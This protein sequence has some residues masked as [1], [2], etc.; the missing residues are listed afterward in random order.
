MEESYLNLINMQIAIIEKSLYTLNDYLS[1]QS[2]ANQR[3]IK[4][5]S[6]VTI[7]KNSIN[8]YISSIS[9]SVYDLTKQMSKNFLS[10][11]NIIDKKIIYN[12]N[13]FSNQKYKT[14]ITSQSLPDKTITYPKIIA[15]S[16]DKINDV[17][18]VKNNFVAPLPIIKYIPPAVAKQD[19]LLSSDRWSLLSQDEETKL[20]IYASLVK[21][22]KHW[23]R[24]IYINNLKH[25]FNLWSSSQQQE[26]HH[27]NNINSPT[28]SSSYS[29]QVPPQI[30]STN[31]INSDV[32][33]EHQYSNN[34]TST[35]INDTELSY[36]DSM[37]DLI[38]NEYNDDGYNGDGY[39]D[40]E[41]SAKSFSPE[42]FDASSGAPLFSNTVVED[43]A[44]LSMDDYW[45]TGG[46]GIV[47]NEEETNY[48]NAISNI[49]G[50]ETISEFNILNKSG[51]LNNN[52]NNNNNS[53]NN[54]NNFEDNIYEMYGFQSKGSNHKIAEYVDKQLDMS[55]LIIVNENIS[56]PKQSLS[57]LINTTTNNNNYNNSINDS[58]NKPMHANDLINRLLGPALSSSSITSKEIE[59]KQEKMEIIASLSSLNSLFD[60]G[61]QV[62]VP[63]IDDS[64]N[65]I[66]SSFNNNGINNSNNN[67]DRNFRTRRIPST[68]NINRSK[69]NIYKSYENDPLFDSVLNNLKDIDEL[70][71]SKTSSNHNINNSNL[72]LAKQNLELEKTRHIQIGMEKDNDVKM[73]ISKDFSL[74]SS[75][76]KMHDP[77]DQLKSIDDG[78]EIPP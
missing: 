13:N 6:P 43:G 76:L 78:F 22:S 9:R 2:T 68:I 21:L 59:E 58:D 47:V 8:N 35:T 52:N 10:R 73:R 17:I 75:R 50:S 34:N 41:L 15:K 33:F 77:E 72:L 74:L 5:Q 16:P 71:P 44:I 20:F 45:I 31:N 12:H 23:Y 70:T 11:N 3:K 62:I 46:S 25:S 69:G 18:V 38:I 32:K 55:D 36:N 4:S 63:I 54:N 37:N 40:E 53:S 67:V 51:R 60:M 14:N 49:N 39:N 61:D 29:L 42:I 30:N 26:Q 7:N 28:I 56:V 64:N 1:L 57:P 27:P 24:N 19:Q 48:I 66:N 65:N